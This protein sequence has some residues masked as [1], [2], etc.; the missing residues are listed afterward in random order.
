MQSYFYLAFKLLIL[1][2]FLRMGQNFVTHQ[3]FLP[4]VIL[5]ECGLERGFA[6][7]FYTTS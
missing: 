2:G 7:I 5:F 3:L 6:E 1:R 4:T